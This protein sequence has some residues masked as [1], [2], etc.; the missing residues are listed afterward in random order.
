[1]EQPKRFSALL[2]VLT[3]G[4]W[5]SPS[6]AQEMSCTFSFPVRFTKDLPA[7]INDALHR[8][9]LY[10]GSSTAGPFLWGAGQYKEFYF[11]WSSYGDRASTE[12]VS[13]Y[14]M[15]RTDKV[16]VRV[17][18]EEGQWSN[19]SGEWCPRTKQLLKKYS[20]LPENPN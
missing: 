1:M 10:P 7:P 18:Q 11:V 6:A 17:A 12:Y 15:G 3:L 4:L 13:L 5:A 9:G 2:A 20:G 8:D 19:D 14:K 16:S